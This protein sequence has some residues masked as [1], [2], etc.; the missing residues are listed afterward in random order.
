MAEQVL[1]KT[2]AP[3]GRRRGPSNFQAAGDGVCAFARAETVLPTKTL[4]LESFRFRLRTDVRRRRSAVRFAK[5]MTAADERDVPGEYRQV[6]PRNLAAVL[7]FDRPEK[8]PRFI[9]T[10]VIRPTVQ[11]SEALLASATATTTIASAISSGAMPGHAN[12]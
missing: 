8:A 6:G 5:G 9:Q 7:L 2:C 11:W 3:F 1:K 4:C 10:D 12:E